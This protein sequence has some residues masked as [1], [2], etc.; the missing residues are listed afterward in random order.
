MDQVLFNH[1]GGTSVRIHLHRVLLTGFSAL[2]FHAANAQTTPAGA[3]GAAKEELAEVVVT[4]SRLI[5]NGN[6]SPTPLTVVADR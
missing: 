2:L 4:G 6:D 3:Q 1:P 5:Q